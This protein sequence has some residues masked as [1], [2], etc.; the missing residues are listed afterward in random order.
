MHQNLH[1]SSGPTVPEA[2]TVQLE[3]TPHSAGWGFSGLAVITLAPGTQW[4]RPQ[5]AAESLVLPLAG[6]GC[7][8]SAQ[9]SAGEESWL[10]E[11]RPDVFSGPSD[12][13][14]LPRG[15]TITLDATVAAPVR[16]ALAT[17]ASAAE[18]P[19]QHIARDQ[20]RVEL[21]GAGSCSRRVSN[22]TLA[23]E[24][25]VEH[26]LVCEVVTPGGNWSSYPPHKHDVHS[27]DERELEEIYYFE[28][29]EG[30]AGAGVAY[31]RTYG[32]PAK[33]IDFLAEVRTGDCVLVPH[34][35]HGPCMAAPG[36][37]LY[38]LNVMA[39]PAEDGRWLSTDDP[40][41]G[42]IRDTWVEQ[43]LD[44]RLLDPPATDPTSQAPQE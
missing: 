32:T 28:I 41:F 8:V 22:Y 24:V 14:Y 2:A 10:L 7:R 25:S 23:T 36:H 6:G 12:A 37:D 9:T 1:L 26:L 5:I 40:A 15:A 42:W 20:V 4:R 3:V 44:P 34:G 29:A 35:Y 30:P 39:G 33:P 19:A 13:V 18:L 21:R 43:S 27:D 11:G 31:H 17:A 38:Y 16:V